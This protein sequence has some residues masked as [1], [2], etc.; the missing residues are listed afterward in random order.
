MSDQDRQNIAAAIRAALDILD[1]TTDEARKKTIRA[2]IK[3]MRTQM[4]EMV[5]DDL[6]S[7]AAAVATAAAEMQKVISNAQAHID[8]QIIQAAKDAKAALGSG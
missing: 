3:A 1:E 4:N 2:S 7:S 5:V 8:G 6:S